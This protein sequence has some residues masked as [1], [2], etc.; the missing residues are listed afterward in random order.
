MVKDKW[1][2]EKIIIEDNSELSCA[3]CQDSFKIG[4]NVIKL[5]CKDNQTHYYHYDIDSEICE[6]IL[7]WL[8]NNNTCPVCRTEFPSEN[9]LGPTRH[10]EPEPE[11]GLPLPESLIPTSN[12]DLSPEQR[13]GI[14]IDNHLIIENRNDNIL[15]TSLEQT[16]INTLD[17]YLRRINHE[18]NETNNEISND[19]IDNDLQRAIE[20]SLSEN[21]D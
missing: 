20:L 15:N 17:N 9:N 19:E 5:P 14:G 7:P 12:T 6:G 11:G 10:A 1:Q 4:D 13:H 3:I 2:H 21:N 8:K 18:I 16:I